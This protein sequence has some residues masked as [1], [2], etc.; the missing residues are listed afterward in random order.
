ML[1]RISTFHIVKMEMWIR[2]TAVC[3]MPVKHYKNICFISKTDEYSP[4]KTSIWKCWHIHA[5][6]KGEILSF[7][8]PKSSLVVDRTIIGTCCLTQ[9][10]NDSDYYTKNLH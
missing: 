10:A 6:S 8:K 4:Y 7:E 3:V 1:D 2:K 9:W 5:C